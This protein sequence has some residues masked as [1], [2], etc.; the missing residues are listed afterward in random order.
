MTDKAN[1]VIKVA[2]VYHCIAHYREPIFRLLCEQDN[3]IE[4]T[5]VSGESD[6]TPSLNTVDIGKAKIPIEKGGLRWRLVKNI[7][8]GK[9]L[10][11]QS[12]V[13]R[14]AFSRE[15][16]VIIYLGVVYHLSTWVSCF[17][18][19]LIGKK[20][21]M[22]SHG[23]LRKEAGLKGTIRSI[24]YR[25]CD[26]MFLYHHRARDILIERGFDPRKLDVLYN[27][28]DVEKQKK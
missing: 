23:Y 13:V 15:F 22:W 6:H 1:Q 11:W 25:L 5:L 4:Y 9:K 18:A 14:L 10:L 26:G 7:W 3:G 17:L 24:F 8:F 12:G 21:Y 19:R 2:I 27:S 20:T 28:L 16:D